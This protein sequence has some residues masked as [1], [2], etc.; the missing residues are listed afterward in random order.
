M[1]IPSSA[2]LPQYPWPLD[3]RLY[4]AEFLRMAQQAAMVNGEGIVPT[5][6]FNAVLPGDL[7]VTTGGVGLNVSAA[8]GRSMVQGDGR[9]TQGLYF[10]YV[11]VA[12]TVTMPA[13]NAVNP[14][15]D[16]VILQVEDS[17]VTGANNDWL[18]TFQQG[19]ATAGATLANLTGGPGQAGG[20]ALVRFTAEPRGASGLMVRGEPPLRRTEPLLIRRTAHRPKGQDAVGRGGPVASVCCAILP[21]L[22]GIEHNRRKEET[23]I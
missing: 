9:S 3:A 5:A 10:C 8:P 4:D 18:V 17:D 12:K 14:R 6:A 7:L 19:T 11:D 22:V 21:R 2:N 23:S 16:A 20:P 13:A 1:T 15:I